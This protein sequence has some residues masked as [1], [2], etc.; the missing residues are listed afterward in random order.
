[1]VINYTQ[2]TL[3]CAQDDSKGSP[4]IIKS[5]KSQPFHWSNQNCAKLMSVQIM[6]RESQFAS[7][8]YD[9]SI[10]FSLEETG[11][12]TLTNRERKDEH[13][14]AMSARAMTER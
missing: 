2:S 7:S 3:I 14:I 4:L 6:P 10:G 12:L 8:Q 1:M 13:F 9:W 5:G 11:S